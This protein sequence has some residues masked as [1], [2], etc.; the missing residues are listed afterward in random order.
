MPYAAKRRLK[1]EKK[2]KE[3]ASEC[4]K[5]NSFFTRKSSNETCEK[6]EEETSDNSI[7][8]TFTRPGTATSTSSSDLKKSNDNTL[9]NT[10]ESAVTHQC[11]QTCFTCTNNPDSVEIVDCKNEQN[12][13]GAVALPQ[14][15]Q[16]Q[17]QS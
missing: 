6:E 10:P 11:K 13:S 5:I 12:E 8:N 17:T 16:N 14:L 9:H 4:K 15:P 3:E 7:A 2:L 1:N